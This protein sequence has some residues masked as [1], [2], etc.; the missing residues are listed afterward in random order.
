MCYAKLLQSCLILCDLLNY[1]P[2]GFSVHGIIQAIMPCPPPGNLPDLGIEP[3][4]LA[5]LVLGGMFFT[6]RTSG[7]SNSVLNGTFCYNLRTLT[8][9][10]RLKTIKRIPR[11]FFLPAWLN[12]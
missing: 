1:S 6:T 8:E 5:S 7:K 2:L 4:S 12:I 9:A 10:L 3:T 11:S